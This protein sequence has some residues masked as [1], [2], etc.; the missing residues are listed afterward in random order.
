MQTTL[1]TVVGN[2]RAKGTRRIHLAT[3]MPRNFD[4]TKETARTDYNAWLRTLPLGAVQT[5]DFSRAVESAPG[6]ATLDS[7]VNF[8]GTHLNR[9]G[10]ARMAAV[11][12]GTLAAWPGA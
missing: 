5:W 4:A 10:Y 7:A 8:D 11:V 12:T 9:G 1:A 3:V 2:I 6:A